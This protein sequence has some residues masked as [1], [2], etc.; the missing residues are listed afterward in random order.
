MVLPLLVACSHGTASP[1]GQ[2]AVEALVAA[3]AARRPDLDVR[4]AFVDV[5]Q[6]DPPRVLADAAGRPARL[7]PLLLSAGY[8]VFVD[9]QRA[10]ADSPCASVA[11]AL[12]P[13]P[14]LAGLLHERLEAVGLRSGDRVVLGAAGSSEPSAVAD[15]AAVA[16]MLGERLRRPVS[17]AYLSAAQPR[18]DAAVASLKGPGHRV[19]VATYLLAPGFF[20][21]LAARSGADVVTPPLL[22]PDEPVPDVLVDIVLERYLG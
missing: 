16:E 21:D 18:L 7:V 4:A 13:D 3:L 1:D 17:A 22:V 14:R 5:Q 2:R 8:H 19:V 6:P 20:A 10:A 15:C 9:L 12:G 11:P